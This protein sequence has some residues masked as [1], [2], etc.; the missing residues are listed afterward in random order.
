MKT[1]AIRRLPPS[2]VLNECIKDIWVFESREK[3]GEEELRIIAPNGCSCIMRG[4]SRDRSAGACSGFRNTGCTS[5][6]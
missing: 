5:R 4:I 1:L 3:L 2:P 6:G